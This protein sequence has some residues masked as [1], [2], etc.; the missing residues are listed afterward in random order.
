[1]SPLPKRAL[2]SERVAASKQ[3]DKILSA[4]MSGQDFCRLSLTPRDTIQIGNVKVSY[5]I[6]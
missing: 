4:A 6:S 3:K 1:M 2:H 5:L